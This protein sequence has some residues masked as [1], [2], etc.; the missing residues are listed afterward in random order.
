MIHEP[1][2]RLRTW[3]ADIRLAWEERIWDPLRGRRPC[4]LLTSLRKDPSLSGRPVD[5]ELDRILRT[6]VGRRL[7]RDVLG[8]HP[9]RQSLTDF[10]ERGAAQA[11]ALL[12]YVQPH[13]DLLEFGG[14]VGRLGRAIAPHVHRLV[15]ADV[16]PVMKVYGRRLS[17]GVDFRDCD[18]LPE[19]ADFDGAY[20]IAVFFHLTLS[21]QKQALE[22]VHRRLKPGGWFLVDL[23]IGPRTTGP[24][25]G[26]GNVGATALE[27]FR[28][29][30]EPLFTARPV[31]LFN[32]GFLLRKKGE[33]GPP[34]SRSADG[35]Y[36][37]D[38]KS[39]VFDVLDGEVVVVNLDNGSYY[40]L[41]G[42]GSVVWQM[43]AAGRRV[44]EITEALLR[45]YEGERTAVERSVAD[46]VAQMEQESLLVAA[47][48][49]ASAPAFR[50]DEGQLAGPGTPFPAPVMYR[51][52]DMQTLIQMDPIREYD[53][54]GWP[55]RRTSPPPTTA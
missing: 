47:P 25:P 8:D 46:F 44:P 11:Q 17:P 10:I 52:T 39:I 50:F 42:A 38:D 40:I 34:H 27:D 9:R 41:E 13:E 37:I 26:H 14:G 15:S 21:Q 1:P 24:L 30:C 29:L 43:L 55:R 2:S 36:A 4:P 19:S 22:Y 7:T 51:Y 28:A 5:R 49:T 45:H 54:T 20:S 16:N 3:A 35:R 12:P 53:E 33:D 32:S 23:K 48:P 6:G 18:E 31:P